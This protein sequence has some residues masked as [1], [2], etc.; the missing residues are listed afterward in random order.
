VFSAKYHVEWYRELI[1][2]SGGLHDT[3]RFARLFL[4]PGMNRCG[5]GPSTSQFDAFAA[6]VDWVE[7]DSAPEQIVGAAPANTPWP[8]RTR[9]CAYPKQTRYKGSGDINVAA[10]FACRE[11]P[12]Y[13]HH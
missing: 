2:D 3:Q 8:G 13:H 10:N 4:V 7:N 1:D 12:R 6:L 5:G 11:A 9:L